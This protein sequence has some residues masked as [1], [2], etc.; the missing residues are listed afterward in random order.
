MLPFLDDYL[1]A[2]NLKDQLIRPR[3]NDVQRTVQTNW[4]RGTTDH[5]QPKKDSFRYCLPLITNTM[6]KNWFFWSIIS[7]NIDDQRILQSTKTGHIQPKEVVLGTNF[8]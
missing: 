5:T 7:R 3:D 8:A 4:T 2:K 6:Q 1:Q